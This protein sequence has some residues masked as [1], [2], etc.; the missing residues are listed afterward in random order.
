[1]FDVVV[2]N[3]SLHYSAD[4]D[5]TVAEALRVLHHDGLLVIIDSPIYRDP[6]SGAAMVRER[7]ESFTREFGFPSN[8]VPME[9]Y[10]TDR[11]LAELADRR[12]V[13]WRQ[14]RP[15]HG[16]R[17]A[18]RPW[19]A[20]LTRSREPARF[21][22]IVGQR[23]AETAPDMSHPWLR[24]RWRQGLALAVPLRKRRLGRP[25]LERVTGYP[26]LVLPGVF[27]PRLMRSGEFL[28]RT[29]DDRLIPP[30]CRVLDMGTGT[31]IGAVAAS[32]WAGQVVAVDINPQAVRCARVNA[33]LNGV[34]ERVQVYHG[35]LF[36]PVRG[37][38]FDVVLFNPPY[39]RGQ[40]RD[41]GDHAWRSVD[42]VE[43]FARSLGR[44]L[45]PSGHA[46]V[47]LSTDG[48]QPGFLAAIR[49]H[50]FESRAV[51]RRDV[52]NEILTVYQLTRG[53]QDTDDHPL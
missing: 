43:R 16:V 14:L 22:V 9:N 29:L 47:V 6:S 35:D 10:L 53:E 41:L 51:A 40:P 24:R 21:L 52:V 5:T 46:L 33:L 31:G 32:R 8:A 17:W 39:Y 36:A 34:E 3:A 23:S 42:V 7:E 2:F 4:F 44:H 48:D 1:Q 30:G 19:R 37:E 15:N 38:C 20:R 25:V 18:L 13:R 11:R 49:A 50:G 12:G 28:A 45:S 26:I 27:N